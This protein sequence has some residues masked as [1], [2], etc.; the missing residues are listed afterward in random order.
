ML[1][2]TESVFI[3]D[4]DA[5]AATVRR[6]HELGVGVAIDDF[7]TGYASLASLRHLPVEEVKIDQAFVRE[8]RVDTPDRFIAAMIDLA[9]ALQLYVVAEGVESEAQRRMLN[10]L[11]CDALQGYAIGMPMDA[12]RLHDFARD[13]RSQIVS[14]ACDCELG[15][16]PRAG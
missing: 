13:L 4:A 16:G 9:H 5:A 8:M 14:G 12:V 10:E 3:N 1:E 7:G 11:H 6:L 15:G 2:I